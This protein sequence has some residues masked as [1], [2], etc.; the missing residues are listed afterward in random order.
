MKSIDLTRIK[1]DYTESDFS[2]KK[3]YLIYYYTDEY[4]ILKPG[5]VLQSS[6]VKSYWCSKTSKYLFYTV[7][8]NHASDPTSANS[9]TSVYDCLCKHDW[10]AGKYGIKCVEFDNT[11]NLFVYL[12]RLQS[13]GDLEL[14]K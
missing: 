4:D 3:I 11:Q 9:S 14:N 12:N 10:S 8:L 7:S 5:S 6:I 2:D 13:F 1:L